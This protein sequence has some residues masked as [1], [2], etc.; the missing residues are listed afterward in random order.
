MTDLVAAGDRTGDGLAD[1]LAVRKDGALVL[2]P[3]DGRGWVTAGRVVGWGFDALRSV[4]GAGDVDHDGHPDLLA[5]NRSTGQLLRYPGRA[6]GDLSS[7]VVWGSGWQG[8]DQLTTGPDLDGDGL[9]GDLVARRSDGRMRTYYAAENGRLYRNNEWGS[10]WGAMDEIS[11]GADW[12]GD[13]VPDLVGRN[14]SNGDLRLYAGTGQRDFSLAP[15]ALDA[16]VE[17][18]DL[19]RVVGDLDGDGYADAIARMPNGDLFGYRGLGGGRFERLPARI[20]HGWEVFDLLEP[21]GDYTN[22]GVPDLLART[23]DGTLRVYAM[24]AAFGFPWSIVVGT[25]WQGA[26]SITGAGALNGDANADV[27]A[28]WTDGSLRIYRGTGP[29]ALN[30]YEVSRPGQTDLVRILGVGDMNGDGPADVLG[31]AA[32]GRLWLYAGD[33]SGGFAAGR[34]PVTSPSVVDRVLG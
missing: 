17:G 13:G 34:Q 6:G 19:F 7:P 24:T 5:V 10:G 25:G 22:D 12:T 3:G 33:G 26:R 1:L 21:V 23:P 16:D 2:Y 14:R 27:V 31:Q 29:G 20:G 15:Q 9:P 28:L 30:Y 32:D 4:T 8:L 11:S 18:A